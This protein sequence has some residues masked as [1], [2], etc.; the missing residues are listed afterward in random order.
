[1]RLV[2]SVSLSR[3][4]IVSAVLAGG[5]IAYVLVPPEPAA[6][7]HVCGG[8][9]L[10]DPAP[11]PAPTQA[12]A[13]AEWK[14]L[15][16]QAAELPHYVKLDTVPAGATIMVN[17]EVIGKTPFEGALPTQELDLSI[18]FKLEGYVPILMPVNVVES[19]ERCDQGMCL[20]VREELST[21]RIGDF[22]PHPQPY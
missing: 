2:P 11:A 15:E 16:R 22:P 1:M 19:F 3:L 9:T 7:L 20:T 17:D 13:D 5:I 4:T 14:E 8:H 18:Q 6:P 10:A 21:K 12:E